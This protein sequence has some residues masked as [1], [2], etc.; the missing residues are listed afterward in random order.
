MKGASMSSLLFAIKAAV[1]LFLLGLNALF[2]MLPLLL[3]ILPKLAIPSVAWRNG[4]TRL[5]R[6][7]A[8][9]WAVAMDAI[10]RLTSS[11]DWDVEL[12]PE[13]DDRSGWYLLLC[14]H[15]SWVDITVLI[16]LFVKRLP[17]PVFFAKKELLRLPVLGQAMWGLDFPLVERHTRREV[18]R[19]PELRGR[20]L[21]TV[22]TACERARQMPTTLIVYPEGTRFSAEKHRH[23]GSPFRHLLSPRP[24][25]TAVALTTLG[26]RLSGVL[27]V[28]IAYPQGRPGLIAALV[29]RTGPVIV[30]GRMLEIPPELKK[31]DYARDTEFRHRHKEWLHELWRQK[32]ELLNRL[33]R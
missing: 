17:F 33:L 19:N 8:V 18:Q 4:C 3:L 2:W 28:T 5:M 21:Q 9:G 30:R 1:V 20:D 32:D 13:A 23:Q 29:G 26:E 31:G 25:G 16:R 12:P 27:D 22:R 10:L 24:G 15:Q 14:N 7:L 11:S 6:R